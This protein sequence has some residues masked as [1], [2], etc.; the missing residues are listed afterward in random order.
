M[1][2]I[3]AFLSRIGDEYKHFRQ[4]WDD[5]LRERETTAVPLV[6]VPEDRGEIRPRSTETETATETEA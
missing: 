6:E 5:A 1:F 2:R 3:Y 4:E